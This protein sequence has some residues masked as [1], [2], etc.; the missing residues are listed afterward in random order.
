MRVNFRADSIKSIED[1]R[2][3]LQKIKEAVEGS[4]LENGEFKFFE[5]TVKKAVTN[6]K[7]SHNLNFTPKDVL[8]LSITGVGGVTWNYSEF[9]SNFLDLTTTGACV[10]RAYIGRHREG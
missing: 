9:D 10:V 3:A 7:Y 8:Q 1:I 5:I 2:D 4:V 6:F